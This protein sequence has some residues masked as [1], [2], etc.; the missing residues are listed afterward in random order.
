MALFQEADL[1]NIAMQRV[2]NDRRYSYEGYTRDSVE[3]SILLES[4][5]NFNNGKKILIFFC[6]I[7]S[8]IK[9]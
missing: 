5:V 1:R 3:K 7:A 8:L 4:S 9:I 2:N 6:H